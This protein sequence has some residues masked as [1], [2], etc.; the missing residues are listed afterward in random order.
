MNWWQKWLLTTELNQFTDKFTLWSS[1]SDLE[2][3][4]LQYNALST[5]QVTSLCV[6]SYLMY[7]DEEDAQLLHSQLTWHWLFFMNI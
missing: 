1:T 3:W 5:V 2:S 6:V 4:D 7:F